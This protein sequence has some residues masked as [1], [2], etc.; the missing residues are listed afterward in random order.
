MSCHRCLCEL[1]H[2]ELDLSEVQNFQMLALGYHVQPV[3][4]DKQQRRTVNAVPSMVDKASAHQRAS[5][6]GIASLIML[7]GCC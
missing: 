7:Y 1:W 4:V 2:L 5:L 3:H 6:V